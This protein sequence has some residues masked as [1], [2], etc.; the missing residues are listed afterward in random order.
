MAAL[1]VRDID[2]DL[3][4]KLRV[5]A[6]H[7]GRSME[8]EARAILKS[9]LEPPVEPLNLARGIRDA[10]ARIGGVELELPPRTERPRAADFGE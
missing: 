10:F 5:Q 1:T 4:S 3:K 8:A 9:A 6:A 2:D 7:N